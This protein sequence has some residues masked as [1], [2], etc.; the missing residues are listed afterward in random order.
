MNLKATLY[1]FSTAV[2]S[3]CSLA[4]NA[5]EVKQPQAKILVAVYSWSGNT[6]HMAK[7]IQKAT[8]A[9]FLEITPVK[10]YP[11]DMKECIQQARTEC[12]NGVKPE[13]S[14]KLDQVSKYDIIFIGSPN[15]CGTMAPPVRTFLA[16]AKLN[17][18]TLIPFFTHGSGGMQ[19]C[20]NDVKALAENAGAKVLKAKA[21]PGKTIKNSNQEIA[22]WAKEALKS[23]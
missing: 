13:L 6:L 7:E 12:K 17:G 15:W 21:L 9:D 18:K 3:L 23:K 5:Q 19:Q 22:T 11:A 20:E 14:T 8:G 10:P 4:A 16:S 2:I 1:T